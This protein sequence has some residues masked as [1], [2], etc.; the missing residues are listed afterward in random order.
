MAAD[1]SP[2]Q[3][4]LPWRAGSS[5]TMGVVGFLCRTF[6]LGFNRL[7]VNG[8]EQFNELLEERNDVQ[9]RERGLITVSNH[10]SVLDDPTIWGALPYRYHWNPDNSRWSL[11][12]H[13]IAFPNKALSFFFSLGQTL[14]THRSAHSPH[15]GLFQPTMTQAIRLLSHGPFSKPNAPPP[16][17]SLSSPDIIDP[18]TSSHLTYSTNGEDTFPAP[19]AYESRR[20]AWVHIFPEGM[21][22]QKGDKTMRYFKW[23]VSR[24][25]LEAEPVPD[26][27]PMWIEGFDQVMHESREWPRPVPRAG[28]DLSVTFGEKVDMEARFGD[29]RERWQA[30]KRKVASKKGLENLESVEDVGVL[31]DEELMDGNEAVALR[32]ECTMRVRQEVLKVRRSR[33]LPDEDPK[34]GLIETWRVEGKQSKREGKMEDG[35]WVKDA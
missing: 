14:P 34:A 9:G 26:V 32:K 22:H 7:E 19:S 12:S 6:L 21:I 5:V 11:A 33:G 20:H 23:G 28:K 24:L 27:V 4:S 15:G 3:P 31:R 25:I 8:W 29:L 18:F 17:V 16:S 13:D 30:L 1:E 35:S 10:L 2:T